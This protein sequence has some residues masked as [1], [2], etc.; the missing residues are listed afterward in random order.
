LRERF[1]I[2]LATLGDGPVVLRATDSLGNLA[3][4]E[5][6]PPKAAPRK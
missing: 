4:L 1:S 3:T 2:P 5:V 6:R